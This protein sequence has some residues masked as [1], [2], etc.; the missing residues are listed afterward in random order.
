[1]KHSSDVK[2][3]HSR[4]KGGRH[5][6]NY[7]TRLFKVNSALSKSSLK[8]SIIIPVHVF[9]ICQDAHEGKLVSNKEEPGIEIPTKC[10]GTSFH[11]SLTIKRRLE[12]FNYVHLYCVASCTAVDSGIQLARRS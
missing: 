4:E 9:G 6:L 8:F 2:E 3:W 11:T 1:M 7:K 10:E 5:I 12:F